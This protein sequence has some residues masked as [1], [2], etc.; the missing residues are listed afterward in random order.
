MWSEHRCTL[1][2]ITLL[3]MML[4]ENRVTLFGIM[5]SLLRMM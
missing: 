4:T 1:L 2:G 5:R 3:R